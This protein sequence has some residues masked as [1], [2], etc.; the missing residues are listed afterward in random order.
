MS[1]KKRRIIFWVFAVIFVIGAAYAVLY[2]SGWRL[3]LKTLVFEKTGGIYIKSQPID[4]LITIDRKSQKSK[5]GLIFYKGTLFANFSHRKY[6]IKVSKDGFWEWS[7]KLDVEPLLVAQA[8]HIILLPKSPKPSEVFNFPK[9]YEKIFYS[10]SYDYFLVKF[11]FEKETSLF[12]FNAK[13]NSF[14]LAY[15]AT[16]E[17]WERNFGSNENFEIQWS[18]NE[19]MFILADYAFFIGGENARPLNIRKEF[20]NLLAKKIGSKKSGVFKIEEIL[21]H[22]FL[23]NSFLFKVSYPVQLLGAAKTALS[24]STSKKLDFSSEKVGKSFYMFNF[25][26]KELAE[27]LDL[28]ESKNEAACGSGIYWIDV[29]DRLFHFNL[30]SKNHSLLY[31]VSAPTSSQLRSIS[32]PD[33]IISGNHDFIAV[34]SRNGL[35]GS[36]QDGLIDSPQSGGALYIFNASKNDLYKPMHSGVK[37]VIFS[38]D[39]KKL[40][41]LEDNFLKII[42]LTDFYDD[43]IK[44]KGDIDLIGKYKDIKDFF[45]HSD[46]NHLWVKT[47]EKLQLV[48]IDA[49]DKINSMD[50]QNVDSGA[51]VFLK[52][53]SI[54]SV[55]P[56]GIRQYKIFE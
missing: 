45:W 32:E 29:F 7:K 23:E 5:T 51:D 43:F 52:D 42:Y 28:T 53:N 38:P 10:P 9:R 6:N 37:K 54:Y 41:V 11:N 31:P 1:L 33:L 56:A 20:Y 40:A 26:K 18:P 14:K 34:V 55:D 15:Q 48:E 44:K 4:V 3:N 19:K 46:S 12:V 35:T 16:E 49:R 8:T 17:E 27:I 30:I 50:L 39:N 21:W 22:P 25:D 24:T 13:N 2:S 36:P 47:A